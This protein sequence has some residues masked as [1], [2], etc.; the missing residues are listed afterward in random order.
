MYL[1]YICLHLSMD[2]MY[3]HHKKTHQ[4]LDRLCGACLPLHTYIHTYYVCT[5][6]Y[7]RTPHALAALALEVLCGKVGYITLHYLTLHPS[8]YSRVLACS[9]KF[10]DPR[11][12]GE[13]LGIPR[14]CLLL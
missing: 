13:V 14:L 1:R 5:F 3:L 10:N 4:I 9:Y 6:R 11:Q 12:E 8:S 2:G 7:V